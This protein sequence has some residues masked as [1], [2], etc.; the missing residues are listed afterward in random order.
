M[1]IFHGLSRFRVALCG[2]ISFADMIFDDA[3]PAEFPVEQPTKFG[4]YSPNKLQN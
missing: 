3:K 4:G 2:A 1:V